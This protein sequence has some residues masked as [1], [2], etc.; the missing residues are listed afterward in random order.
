MTALITFLVKEDSLEG[1][2]GDGFDYCRMLIERNRELSVTAKSLEL[3]LEHY[4]T[5][6]TI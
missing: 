1:R 3:E 4:K 5:D 6:T 2:E